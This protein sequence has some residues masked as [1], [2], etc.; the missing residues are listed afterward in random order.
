MLN[1]TPTG[2]VSLY[3]SADAKSVVVNRPFLVYS[4]GPILLPTVYTNS[5]PLAD[6]GT[7][8]PNVEGV[9][10]LLYNILLKPLE[11]TKL[12]TEEIP[13]VVPSSTP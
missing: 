7:S 13:I 11:V 2:P 12:L 8:T 10:V 5:N 3:S 4:V 9:R 6:L 1:T